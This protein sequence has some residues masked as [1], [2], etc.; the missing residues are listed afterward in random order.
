MVKIIKIISEAEDLN[1]YEFLVKR[2]GRVD[3]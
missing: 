2:Y 1:R 3:E